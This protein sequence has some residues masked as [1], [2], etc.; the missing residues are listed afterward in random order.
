MTDNDLQTR[1]YL[2]KFS[3]KYLADQLGS[4][5]WTQLSAKFSPDLQRLL[6]SDIEHAGWYPIA[7]LSELMRAIVTEL[8]DNDN[9]RS[10]QALYECGRYVSSEAVSTFLKLFLKMLTPNIFAKKLPTLLRRDFT[11]GRATV[12]V[13]GKTIRCREYDMHGFDH[14]AVCAAGFVATALENLGKK[15][16]GMKMTD[17][18]VDQPYVD[19]VMFEITWQD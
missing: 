16:V 2:I 4:D 9:E 7:Q 11:R 17:W 15:V 3:A 18:S 10:K 8:G 14:S 1:G 13:E 6:Q 12:E 19:G 5:R